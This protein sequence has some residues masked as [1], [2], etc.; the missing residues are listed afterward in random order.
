MSEF[1]KLMQ[2]GSKRKDVEKRQVNRQQI[3]KT[4]LWTLGIS[5]LLTIIPPHIGLLVFLWIIVRFIGPSLGW[6]TPAD[7]L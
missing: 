2:G 5:F 7:S 3:R 6:W 1:D 4:L